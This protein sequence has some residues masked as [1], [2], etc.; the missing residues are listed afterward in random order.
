[1]NVTRDEMAG[2]QCIVAADPVRDMKDARDLIEEA[3][4]ERA[5]MIVLPVEL[6]DPS[7]FQLRSGFAGELM[8][9][10][11][12][13]GL[14]LAVAGDVSS[15]VAASTALRDL[16]VECDRGASVFFAPSI[17]ALRERLAR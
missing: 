14:K 4:G 5:S 7:F 17:D 3:L 15:Y 13:Y 9:K 10:A 12:N 2:V 11:V 6:L 16:I 8:Q 1:M